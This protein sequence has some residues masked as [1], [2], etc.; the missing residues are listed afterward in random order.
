[1]GKKRSLDSI[2]TI[3]LHCADTPNGRLHTIH[4]IDA[5][6][7]ER[8]FQRDL[9]IAPSHQPGLKH[10]GYHYVIYLGGIVEP[11]RPLIESGAHAKNHNHN[12]I[13]ICLIGRDR[14]NA[15]QWDALQKLIL[16]IQSELNRDLIIV[17]HNQ[18]DAGKTC[19]G[20]NVEQYLTSGMMPSPHNIYDRN[21]ENAKS[22]SPHKP[23]LKPHHTKPLSTSHESTSTPNDPITAPNNKARSMNLLS[24]IGEVIKPATDLIDSLHTSDEEKIQ[25]KQQLL[26]AKN[27]A[28]SK[29]LEHERA[30]L[31]AQTNVIVAEAQGQSWLQRSWRPITMLTFL[32]LIIADTFGLTEFRLSS[33]AWELLKL[34]LGGYVIGR[35]AEKIMPSVMKAIKQ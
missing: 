6:H 28:V 25:A 12:S 4:D 30:L 31:E 10:I 19:P 29:A 5:W 26:L 33:Q 35:S 24:M 8:D 9:S 17:G 1:M 18:L 14:F 23:V 27:N 15:E 20:F 16:R 21:Q 3:V 22:R 7:K 11:G 32:V 13:G 2:T 34:G